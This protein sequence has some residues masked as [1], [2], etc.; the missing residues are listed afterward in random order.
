MDTTRE[1]NRELILIETPIHPKHKYIELP[2]NPSDITVRQE[3]IVNTIRTKGGYILQYWGMGLKIININGST[4]QYGI[5][6]IN[7][8]D[9]V[10]N[11]ENITIQ[12][13]LDS[14]IDLKRRQSLGQLASSIIIWYQNQGWR[15]IINNFTYTERA[16]SGIID[17]T[18]DFI[19]F[20]TIGRRS[21]FLPYHRKPF[22]TINNPTVE[23]NGK[24]QGGG[25]GR[26]YKIGELNT[27]EY[28]IGGRS[29]EILGRNG[30]GLKDTEYENRTGVS[31]TTDKDKVIL[32]ENFSDDLI[33]NDFFR[34]P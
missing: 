5:E 7:V 34:K 17:Y 23:I 27:P 30:I 8:L 14:N 33:P 31:L 26:N 28:P 19:C 10:F 24:L 18:I 15:G 13:I 16:G 25:Y 29:G 4:G 9:D 12:K 22:S 32:T 20:E 21:N 1:K 2:I 11:A 3:K 6:Y